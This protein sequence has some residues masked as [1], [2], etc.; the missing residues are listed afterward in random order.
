MN[1][2]VTGLPRT[3]TA[4]MAAF[5]SQDRICFH[6]GFNGCHSLLE[7]KNKL[8]ID[9]GDSGTA[10]MLM[11]MN[12]VFPNSPILCIHGDVK[13]STQYMYDTYGIYDVDYMNYLEMRL[14]DIKGMHV[15]L[16]DIDIRLPEICEYLLNKKCDYQRIEIFKRLKIEIKNPHDFDE[17]ALKDLWMTIEG[18]QSCH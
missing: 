7:Y 8:G 6:E 10:L 3:R 11:D 15:N 4:W 9:K 12:K 18:M 5:L 16:N 13:R 1:F 17:Q 14:N 2:F